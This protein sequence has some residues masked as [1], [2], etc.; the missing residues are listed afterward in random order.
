MTEISPQKGKNVYAF[1]FAIVGELTV[2][3]AVPAVL[4]AILGKW[5][6]A[7]YATWPRYMYGCLLAAMFL[8]TYIILKRAKALK[9]VYDTQV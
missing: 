5:L 8:S 3:I 7:R 2:V 4:A 6:D 9:A 1:A